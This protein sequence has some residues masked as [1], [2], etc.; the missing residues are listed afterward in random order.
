MPHKANRLCAKSDDPIPTTPLS[1]RA[2]AYVRVSRGE[3]VLGQAAQEDAIVRWCS[4]NNVTLVATHIDI[5]VS[6]DTAIHN[7][8]GLLAALQTLR[9]EGADILL[10][11]KR[12]RLARSLTVAAMAEHLVAQ[13]GARIISTAGEGTITD[14]PSSKSIR[15]MVDLFAA[16]E[17][18]LIRSRTQTAMDFKRSRGECLG[19][20]PIG[21]RVATDGIRLESE[22]SEANIITRIHQLR[23]SGFSI[24]A[25]ARQLNDDCAPARGKQ[26]HAT[27]IARILRKIH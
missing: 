3:Q 10:V 9:Q 25:I 11:T 8:R 26:W 2:V 4:Q 12:D 5:G 17:L 18:H 16:Y 23:S 13:S 14:K 21:Y 19:E 22:P 6:G 1:A 15:Y 27:T 24:R 20:V 7:R